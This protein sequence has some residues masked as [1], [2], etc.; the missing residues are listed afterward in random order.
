LVTYSKSRHLVSNFR[1][2]DTILRWLLLQ[3]IE[4]REMDG[5][6]NSISNIMKQTHYH[7]QWIFCTDKL[8][9]MWAPHSLKLSSK[10]DIF[11]WGS[12]CFLYNR[13]HFPTLFS[14]KTSWVHLCNN[15]HWGIWL[16]QCPPII[17]EHMLW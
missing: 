14:T 1:M 2:W 6:P 4:T 7:I 15:T 11:F 13:L 3:L 12:T 17:C 8:D 5:S 16:R 10:R 9:L